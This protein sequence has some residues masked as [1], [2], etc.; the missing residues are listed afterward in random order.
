M[1]SVSSPTPFKAFTL[2][3]IQLGNI[4]SNKAENLR[5]AREMI[6]RAASG[7]GRS[8]R[9]DLI[10]LPVRL[11]L[12]RVSAVIILRLKECFNSPYGHTHFPNYAENIGFHPGKAYDVG[13]STSESVKMLS[14]AAKEAS[15]WLVGGRSRICSQLALFLMFCF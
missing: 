1:P 4:G 5:H 6:L 14:S 15:T 8:K 9:P 2:A 12:L 10:V 3:L 11:S 13:K 7:Q